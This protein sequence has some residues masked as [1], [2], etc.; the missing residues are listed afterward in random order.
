MAENRT[1][2]KVV[3]TARV[4]EKAVVFGL[5]RGESEGHN[6]VHASLAGT[7]DPRSYIL[8]ICAAEQGAQNRKICL[9]LSR[10]RFILELY[11]C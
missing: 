10:L 2:A 7:G 9:F 4:K 3:V 6:V 5:G 11:K 1:G 8:R